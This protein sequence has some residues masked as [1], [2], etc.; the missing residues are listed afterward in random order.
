MLSRAA[1]VLEEFLE[2]I[3]GEVG[4]V[5]NL[6]QGT[7]FD[8]S[9]ARDNQDG[10]PIGHGHMPALTKDPKPSVLQGADNALMGDLRELGHKVTS[11]ERMGLSFLRSSRLRRYVRMASLMFSRASS[12]DSP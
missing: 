12:S 11:T 7:R 2:L 9:L 6:A 8:N 10:V 4:G 1:N 3:N 5:E